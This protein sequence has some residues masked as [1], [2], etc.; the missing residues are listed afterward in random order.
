[1][2]L[3]LALT[4]L[5]SRTKQ[6]DLVIEA[7]RTLMEMEALELKASKRFAK[8]AI[9]DGD[10]AT[11]ISA[12]NHLAHF[13][14]DYSG[15]LRQAFRACLSHADE[16][17]LESLES[18]CVN[19]VQRIDLNAIKTIHLAN[20]NFALEIVDEGLEQFPDEVLL[21]H[22][23]ANILRVMGDVQGSIKACDLIL[24]VNPQH[25]KASILRTQMGT[26]I[27]D[28]DTAVSEYEK[29]VAA[30]PDCVKFHHQLLNYSYSAKRD[31]T[32]SKKIIEHGLIHVPN[33]LRLKLYKALVHAHLGER[34]LAQ[35]TM[36]DILKT[37]EQR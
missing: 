4:L 30:F 5:G 34:E 21:L 33:D 1:M 26:K 32:W 25:L 2:N 17:S 11:I 9:D 35:R 24:E 28:E 29:M 36:K 18:L 8:A 3:L 23:K 14:V 19:E 20:H 37:S 22:R 6:P 13:P 7:S 16:T 10:P 27:W 15:T 12:M 31:M